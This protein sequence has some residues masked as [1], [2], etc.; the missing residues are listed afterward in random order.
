M[1]TVFLRKSL[2]GRVRVEGGDLAGEDLDLIGRARASLHVLQGDLIVAGR[3]LHRVVANVADDP[4]VDPHLG[5]RIGRDD[6]RA[7]E[8]WPG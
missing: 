3:E 8:D 6:Q 5:L 7:G 1:A 4:A 2:S